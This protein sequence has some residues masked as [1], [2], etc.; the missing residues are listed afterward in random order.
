MPFKTKTFGGE[1]AVVACLNLLAALSSAP[2]HSVD[3]RGF[4]RQCNLNEC[5]VENTVALLQ[6]LADERS[7]ARIAISMDNGVITLLGNAGSLAPLRLTNQE[8]L[9]LRQVLARCKLEEDV[10]AR[11][12]A[13]LGPT[14]TCDDAH[15]L[16]GDALLGGFYPTIAEAMSIGARLRMSYRSLSDA[17]SREREVDPGHI[18]V[19]GDAAYLIAWDIEQDAQRSYRLDRIVSIEITDDS[20]V[21]HPFRRFS[22]AE[23]LRLHGKVSRVSWRSENAFNLCD[24]AGIDAATVEH[25]DDG[26]V[27]AMVS[28]TS[29][30]WFFDQILGGGGD[31][32]IIDPPEARASFLSYAERTFEQP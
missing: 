24:W 6:T 15:L 30:P 10:R 5:D 2:S 4:Q 14:T 3:A 9:A 11:I 28:Y 22:P 16:S 7:G 32:L 29:E 19:A 13:A 17:T 27:E 31:I 23:S 26:R 1:D 12:D 18:E 20:V 25:L 21:E 8:S